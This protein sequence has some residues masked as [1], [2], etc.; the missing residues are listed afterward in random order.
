MASAAPSLLRARELAACSKW[1]LHAGPRNVGSIRRSRCLLDYTIHIEP[2]SMS[3]HESSGTALQ[4]LASESTENL[5]IAYCLVGSLPCRATLSP[6]PIRPRERHPWNIG[7]VRGTQRAPISQRR[8][9]DT[10]SM[11]LWPW[12]RHRLLT[13]TRSP[14]GSSSPQARRGTASPRR[15]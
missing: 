3:L 7:Y 6:L 1:Q 10:F 5:L 15:S 12:H 11:R 9:R 4:L 2:A 14:G 13:R 8:C